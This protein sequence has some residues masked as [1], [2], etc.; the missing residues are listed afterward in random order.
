MAHGFSETDRVKEAHK[1][2]AG[3]YVR[4]PYALKQLGMAVK[5]ELRKQSFQVSSANHSG[6]DSDSNVCYT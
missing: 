1:L 4:K 5:T 2:G 3:Q 6:L